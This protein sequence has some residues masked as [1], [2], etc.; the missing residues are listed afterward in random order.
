M[1]SLLFGISGL[2]NR[3]SN[4]KF[5]YKTGIEYLR[6][7]GLDAMELPF[8]RSVNITDKNKNEVLD[9]KLKN[10]FYLSAHGSY[11]INLNA[12]EEEKI[13]KSLERIIKGA[14]GLK[15]VQGKSLIFHP[16]FY[17]KDSKEETFETIKENLLRL[18]DLGVDYRLETTGKGTQFGSLEENVALCKAVDTCKLCID[19]SHI[20]ARYNGSLKSYDD[21]ARIL[22]Y[23]GNELGDE[24]LNDMHIHLSGINYTAKGE[25]NHLPFEESDFNYKDCLKAFRDFD[26]KGCVICESPVLEHDALLLKNYYETL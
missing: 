25:R 15:K 2:P 18:P 11:F 1:D 22:N 23:V 12:D 21:F 10:D 9:T 7:I 20:H 3:N 13:E 16:G 17:L 6:E 5:T 24:G 19:F 26:I 4:K 8:V 14:E